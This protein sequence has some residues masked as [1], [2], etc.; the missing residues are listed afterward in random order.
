MDY[1]QNTK[2]S[3]EEISI[4]SAIRNIV[5][6]K[7]LPDKYPDFMLD[8]LDAYTYSLRNI[9]IDHMGFVLLSKYWTKDLSHWIGKR[10]CLELMAGLGA[11]SYGLRMQGINIIATDDY[12]WKKSTNG[13]NSPLWD[14][15]KM[16]TYVEKLDAVESVKKYGKNLDII[17]MSWPPYDD[18]VAAKALKKMREVNPSCIMIYIGEEKGG[19][20]ANDEFYNILERIE[21]ESFNLANAKFQTWPLTKDQPFLIK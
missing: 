1:K 9:F 4:I 12:S 17:I 13:E 20:T 6:K 7:E 18:V 2:L 8:K 19:C 15:N 3:R 14:D 11:L 21:D 10:R 5:E 16:W